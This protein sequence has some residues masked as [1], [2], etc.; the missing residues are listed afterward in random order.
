MPEEVEKRKEKV[1]SDMDCKTLNDNFSRIKVFTTDWCC[2]FNY[3][4]HA[5]QWNCVNPTFS[6][7][8]TGFELSLETF[9]FFTVDSSLK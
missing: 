7:M 3:L 8:L 9:H 5:T 6:K 4:L 2:S 1:G